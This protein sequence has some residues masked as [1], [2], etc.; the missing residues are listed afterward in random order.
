MTKISLD[1]D[2]LELLARVVAMVMDAGGCLTIGRDRAETPRFV[3]EWWT[4]RLAAISYTQEP[5]R[6]LVSALRE[7][8]TRITRLEGG[9]S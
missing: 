2:E 7:A 1:A 3:V 8:D 9:T 5:H 6:D 4:P